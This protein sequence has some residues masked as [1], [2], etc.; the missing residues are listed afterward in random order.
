MDQHLFSPTRPFSSSS[1]KDDRA[2]GKFL[3]KDCCRK[4]T[5]LPLDLVNSALCCSWAPGRGRGLGGGARL[6]KASSLPVDR[7]PS[8]DATVKVTWFLHQVP[9]ST[10]QLLQTRKGSLLITLGQRCCES[11]ACPLGVSPRDWPAAAR[12]LCVAQLGESPTSFPGSP[13]NQDC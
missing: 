1:G 3:L 9:F 6:S 11:F 2:P 10:Q 13:L 4:L 8:L 12:A 7:I 5:S